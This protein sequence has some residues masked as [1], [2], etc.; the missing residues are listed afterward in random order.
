MPSVCRFAD[1]TWLAL[2]AAPLAA[3]GSGSLPG[4]QTPQ[5]GAAVTEPV[6]GARAADLMVSLAPTVQNL[7]VGVRAVPV[8]PAPVLLPRRGNTAHNRALMIVGGA[9]M[10]VGAIVGG[11]AGAIIMIGGGAVG[12]Y[13]LYQYL[14]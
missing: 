12:I 7:A 8:Q 1:V 9:T 11:N 10:L 13:G 3:Q 14:Q 6:Y 2:S 4:P 5:V